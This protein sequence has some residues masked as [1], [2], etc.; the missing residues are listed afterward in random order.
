VA[1]ELSPYADSMPGTRRF[2]NHAWRVVNDLDDTVPASL[3]IL[4]YPNIPRQ[5]SYSGFGLL[6]INSYYGWYKGKDGPQSVA[7]FSGLAPFLRAMKRMYPRQA[8]MVTEFGA[9]A[10]YKGPSDVKETFAFQSHYVDRTLQVVD[11]MPW[12]SGAIYWTAREFF[13]KPDW[14]GGARRKGIK[15]DA[16]HNKGLIKYDGAPKPAFYEARKLFAR[17][18]LYPDG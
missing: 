14:D 16:L 13:V 7:K 12:L 10:T 9:E 4:S 8:Q 15:R 2:L 11:S 18:P 3:D 1:N 17:T 5:R 6:G